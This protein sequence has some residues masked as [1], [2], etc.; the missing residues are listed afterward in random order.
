MDPGTISRRISVKWADLDLKP[1]DTAVRVWDV[2][3]CAPVAFQDDRRNE[4]L[5]FST[6]LAA[7]T[8]KEFRILA[9]ASLP[10]ADL[11]IVCW[12]QY[13]PERMDDFAW[14]ND[15]FGA[16]A[17]GPV[18]MEPAPAGQ[19]LVSSGIDIINK[20]VRYPVLH[21]WFVERTPL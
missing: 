4:A 9:D 17:Y 18:I 15:R 1:D 10:Q 20:C 7:K 8:T 3:A 19:K 16:R 12:S 6:A 11:S 2:A 21:R 5:I 14:E 13:L